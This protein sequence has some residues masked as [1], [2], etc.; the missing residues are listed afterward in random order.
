M[1]GRDVWGGVRRS[2][3]TAAGDGLAMATAGT[4]AQFTIQA[5]DEY[6]NERGEVRLERGEVRLEWGEVRLERGEVR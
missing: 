3:S 4:A 1:G 2:R 5:N 6:D